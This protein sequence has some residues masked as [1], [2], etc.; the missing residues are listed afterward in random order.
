MRFNRSIF[1]VSFLFFIGMTSLQAQELVIGSARKARQRESNKPT[2]IYLGYE[3]SVPMIKDWD[4]SNNFSHGVMLG[5]VKTVGVYCKVK[6]YSPDKDFRVDYTVNTIPSYLYYKTRS[7]Q[8]SYR[9]MGASGGLMLKFRPITFYAG[10]GGG[11]YWRYMDADLYDYA[12]DKVVDS[13][14]LG[15]KNSIEGIQGDAGI[16]I[17][18]G[19]F[20][21]SS[22][23][24]TI[25]MKYYEV[26]AGIGF[27]F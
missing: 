12:Y 6:F 9:R 24:T 2:R 18:I 3:L 13:I 17:N 27:S 25:E 26:S 5:V 23:I 11:Y 1:V 7:F 20:G 10:A 19:R 22:G 21:F 15:D 4:V 16:I 14:V 8:E